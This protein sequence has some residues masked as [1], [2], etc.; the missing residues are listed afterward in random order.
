MSRG[1]PWGGV[2]FFCGSIGAFFFPLLS[3][4]HAGTMLWTLSLSLSLCVD[5]VVGSRTSRQAPSV[6]SVSSVSSIII[7]SVSSI[8]SVISSVERHRATGHCRPPPPRHPP[9][10]RLESEE[11][12]RIAVKRWGN[13][14]WIPSG[15]RGPYGLPIQPLSRAPPAIFL[16]FDS[17]RL[18]PVRS[19][20]ILSRVGPEL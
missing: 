15:I 8:T 1:M 17:S 18:S 6:S 12:G 5:G 3:F 2:L 16:S 19:E 7:R 11:E 13:A 10:G 4:E 14:N 9:P 20:S